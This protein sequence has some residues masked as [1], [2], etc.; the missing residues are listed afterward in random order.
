MVYQ[1][2]QEQQLVSDIETAWSF[3]SSPANLSKITP[4]HMGFQI[5]NGEPAKMYPGQIIQYT[6][7]P[8][9]NIPMRW[10]TE[11]TQVNKPHFFIDSQ[12]HGPYKIWHHQHHF[13]EN[14]KG[15]LMTDIVTY[16]PP[17]GILGRLA[18]K[19]MIEKQVEQIFAY[20]REYIEKN[21]VYNS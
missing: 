8:V 10:V 16:E 7:K 3:F 15:V 20:R 4:D 18:N 21:F 6:V 12:L 17:L 5:L 2:K 9:F 1:F 13:E 14:E 19:L 11:I